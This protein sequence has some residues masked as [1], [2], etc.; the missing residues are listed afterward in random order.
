MTY[1]PTPDDENVDEFETVFVNDNNPG[2]NKGGGS[3]QSS[4]RNNSN[5]NGGGSPSSPKNNNK[6]AMV[7]NQ[8]FARNMVLDPG[9]NRL[10]NFLVSFRWFLLLPHSV[11]Q[12]Y[13][14]ILLAL[15]QY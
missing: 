10:V 14:P 13:V 1:N 9:V 7:P 8:L 12:H 2:K 11:T 5:N 6:L 3:R 15:C 4:A